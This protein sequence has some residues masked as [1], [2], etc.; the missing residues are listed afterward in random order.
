MKYEVLVG[1]NW[2]SKLEGKK[3]AAGK[4]YVEQ[5]CEPGDTL[6]VKQLDGADVKALVAG[7]ALVKVEG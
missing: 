4:T 6:T 2:W 1:F 5:R 7:G 3:R